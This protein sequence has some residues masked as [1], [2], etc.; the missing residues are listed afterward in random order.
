MR[1]K[2]PGGGE[3][4][5]F[6]RPPGASSSGRGARGATWPS[7]SSLTCS[8]SSRSRRTGTS[9]CRSSR[10]TGTRRRPGRPRRRGTRGPGRP[11]SETR[12]WEISLE[13]WREGN[14]NRCGRAASVPPHAVEHPDRPARGPHVGKPLESRGRLRRG[15]GGEHAPGSGHADVAGQTRRGH[16]DRLGRR[17]AGLEQARAAV[18]ARRRCAVAGIDHAAR[19]HAVGGRSTRRHAGDRACARSAAVGSGD[20]GRDAFL[21][22]AGRTVGKTVAAVTPLG[23]RG[24]GRAGVADVRRHGGGG[25]EQ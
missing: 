4:V 14:R 24:A 19:R 1:S 25:E 11:R 10:S 3:S 20:G 22:G 8:T 18:G 17:I 6:L 2:P 15:E 7:G 16:R 12:T 23:P 9:R 13:M 21:P 5:G